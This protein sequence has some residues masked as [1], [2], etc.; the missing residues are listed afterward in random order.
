[1]N[2]FK[3]LVAAALLAASAGSA[4]ADADYTLPLVFDQQGFGS[5]AAVS[6]VNGLF[7]DNYSFDPLNFGGKVSVSFTALTPTTQFFV[8]ELNGNTFS[9]FPEDNLP[10]FEFMS[11]VSA[12]DPLKLTIFGAAT[13]AAG[14][15]VA[16]SYAVNVLAVPEPA[17][18]GL[19]LAGLGVVACLGRR[20]GL[21]ALHV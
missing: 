10:M 21:R 11:V 16:G 2:R 6:S 9:F 8:G 19:M 20:R 14:D 3:C 5:A 15:F 7:V 13:N 1:M 17:T 18:Y 4:L 12:S